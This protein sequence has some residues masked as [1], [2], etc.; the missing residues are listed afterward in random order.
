M[1]RWW[2]RVVVF[3]LWD[4]LRIRSLWYQISVAASVGCS[5][6]W[7][8]VSVILRFFGK[9]PLFAIAVT[10]VFCVVSLMAIHLL[11]T[12]IM[13]SLVAL[14]AR[15]QHRKDVIKSTRDIHEC[16][17]QILFLIEN[18]FDLWR[19]SCWVVSVEFPSWKACWLLCRCDTLDNTSLISLSTSIPNPSRRADVKLIGRNDFVRCVVF[20]AW[21]RHEDYF[22]TLPKFGNVCHA[23]CSTIGYIWSSA[24]DLCFSIEKITH[25]VSFLVTI[26]SLYLMCLSSSHYVERYFRHL[27]IS[28]KMG[29]QR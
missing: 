8:K 26:S 23:F 9:N 7:S 19:C 15:V 12:W 10:E 5:S 24:G 18:V 3:P 13:P 22:D 4:H 14:F 1:E 11:T 27:H 6:Q 28:G 21:L 16:R 20:L 25:S 17:D 2:S 29:W